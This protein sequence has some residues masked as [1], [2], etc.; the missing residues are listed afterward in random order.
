MIDTII[1]G[2]LIDTNYLYFFPSPERYFVVDRVL[3]C[4]LVVLEL[5]IHT[6]GLFPRMVLRMF[7]STKLKLK[8]I[9]N[10]DHF[11][12][13]LLCAAWYLVLQFEYL[14]VAL[15]CVCTS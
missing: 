5:E 3:A 14:D 11:T 8:L 10:L 15:P 4:N 6:G 2:F 13:S 1:S 12:P 9:E 7:K